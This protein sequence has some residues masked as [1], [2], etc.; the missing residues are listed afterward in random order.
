M[1][2]RLA[3]SFTTDKQKDILFLLIKTYFWGGGLKQG[4]AGIRHYNSQYIDVHCTSPNMIH[5]ITLSL[6]YN[7]LLKRL[8]KQRIRKC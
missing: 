5:K 6:D 1:V 3:R 4:S 7:L 8:N 2:Q